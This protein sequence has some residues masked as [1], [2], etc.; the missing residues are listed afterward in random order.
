MRRCSFVAISRLSKPLPHSSPV[1]G[2][3]LILEVTAVLEKL[4]CHDTWREFLKYKTSGRLLSSAEEK[5]LSEYI[6][7]RRYLPVAEQVASGGFR[8]SVP[9]KKEL[10]KQGT[11][12]KRVI[13]CFPED[14]NILL[15]MIAYMLYRYDCV[16]PDNCFS[17]RRDTGARDAFIG[18]TKQP[19]INGLWGFK[20]DISNYFNSIDVSMLVP[21]LREV[22]C[23]DD[24]LLQLMIDLLSDDRAIWQGEVIREKRGVMAGTPTSPFFANIYLREMDEFF[25]ERNVLYA[26]YSDDIIIFGGRDETEES[27]RTYRGF[28]EKYGLVS[29][30]S[31]EQRFAPGE[32]WSF[33][34]FEYRNGTVDISRAASG[35][36]LDKIRRGAKSVR[37]WMLKKGASPERALTAFNRRFNR[38]FYDTASGRELCWCRWYFPMINT[39]ATLRYIDRYMQDWQRYIVTG[40]HNKANYRK[41]P[42]SVLK[43]C[44]YRPLVAEYYRRDK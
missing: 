29:N 4:L 37:R 12:K 15:K 18:M 39:D 34:G 6:E 20:A 3:L 26:R 35:K 13:Y 22:I 44:G 21:V 23:D 30:P 27:I 33:L 16:I 40:K 7:N 2:L 10:N 9:E 1:K 31:K 14:E 28:L 43:D 25:A 32:S 19:E 11:T 36:L 38:K 8:F 5:K 42:Y 24:G 17:F 41:V